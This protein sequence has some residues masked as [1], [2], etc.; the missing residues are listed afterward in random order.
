MAGNRLLEE[1]SNS[2]AA[3]VTLVHSSWKR[4]G[5]VHGCARSTH[6]LRP[7]CEGR[8][9]VGSRRSRQG[10]KL[11]ACRNLHTACCTGMV[12]TSSGVRTT[13]RPR[14]MPWHDLRCLVRVRAI[15]RRARLRCGRYGG[16]CHKRAFR[17]A[18]MRHIPP[19]LSSRSPVGNEI[20]VCPRQTLGMRART[21]PTL[22]RRRATEN[23]SHQA[24]PKV[25]SHH[26]CV[27]K[28]FLSNFRFGFH[29]RDAQWCGITIGKRNGHDASEWFALFSCD[30]ELDEFLCPRYLAAELVHRIC[31]HFLLTSR[32]RRPCGIS[33]F[34]G[35]H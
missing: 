19:A 18:P 21:Q 34:L 3:W 11:A 35:I 4:T 10:R 30:P 9:P 31:L 32:S 24:A 16:S 14:M 15:L 6:R 7:V 25:H 5:L 28:A 22:V 17:A 12:L 33:A 26:F 27:C 13:G 29:R 1:E 2:R 23:Y 8:G 20:S